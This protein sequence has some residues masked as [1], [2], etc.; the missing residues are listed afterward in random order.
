MATAVTTTAAAILPSIQVKVNYSD[1]KE[2]I[3]DFIQNFK[4]TTRDID[5]LE[6]NND[7]DEEVPLHQ[8]K[9]MNILQKIANRETT[10][11]YID[12]DDLKKFL[13]NFDA[14]STSIYQE[15]RHL[16]HTIMIN[17]HRFLEIDRKSVV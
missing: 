12:F 11:I 8:G 3:R 4:D 14:E 7:D 1:C 13:Q 17:T 5:D 16:F 6:N 2:I 15:L 9:Y 10:T